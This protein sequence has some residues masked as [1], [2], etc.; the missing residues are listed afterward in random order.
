MWKALEYLLLE[1]GLWWSF[2]FCFIQACIILGF[3][4]VPKDEGKIIFQQN[5]VLAC[6]L[7]LV[8]DVHF[9]RGR[10]KDH[11]I[12]FTFMSLHFLYY[13][14]SLMITLSKASEINDTLQGKAALLLFVTA[15]QQERH[16]S[17]W[18]EYLPP[19]FFTFWHKN[20]FLQLPVVASQFTPRWGPYPT[21][22]FP[23]PAGF[24]FALSASATHS[25]RDPRK[26]TQLLTDKTVMTPHRKAESRIVQQPWEKQQKRS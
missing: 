13:H 22:G 4:P 8:W 1:V 7:P 19:S 21:P 20:S 6:L 12:F 25:P 18:L 24:A 15:Q 14:F 5:I 11:F 10:E 23:A 17:L 16:T 2:I 26:V 9:N 3:P